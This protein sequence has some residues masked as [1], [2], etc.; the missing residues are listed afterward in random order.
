M[1][2]PLVRS[3]ARAALARGNVVRAISTSNCLSASKAD[4]IME[5][6]PAETLTELHDYDVIPDPK[7]VEAALRACRRVNDFSLCVRFLEAIKIKCG[8][9][10]N[11]EIIYNYIIKELLVQVKPVLDELGISTPEELGY[12]K[13]ELFIPQ[14]D[15]WWEKKWYAE[16]GY[17]KKPAF[18]Y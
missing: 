14:P 13:P 3:I 10:K 4:D 15:Y 2:T 8:S 18:Q 6:W 9:K 5:K 17:D 11:R 16:Y 1:A 7:V 12:D